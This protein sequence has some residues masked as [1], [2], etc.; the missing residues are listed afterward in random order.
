MVFVVILLLSLVAGDWLFCGELRRFS[1]TIALHGRR[2]YAQVALRLTTED[3][4]S[5]GS[6]CRWE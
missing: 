2:H 1:E 5:I 3:R 6:G 4:Q